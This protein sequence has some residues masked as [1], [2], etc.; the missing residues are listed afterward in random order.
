MSRGAPVRIPVLTAARVEMLRLV[1]AGGQ[2]GVCASAP[3]LPGGLLATLRSQGLLERAPP[4][5]DALGAGE[6]RYRLTPVG[7]A[8]ITAWDA[9]GRAGGAA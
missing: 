6:S 5:N 1:A 8:A 7:R 3:L 4:L 9:G 2:A